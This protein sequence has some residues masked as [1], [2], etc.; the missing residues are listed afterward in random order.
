MY[1]NL[2]YI[3]TVFN[4]DYVPKN[5]S[6]ELTNLG[7]EVESFDRKAN[8]LDIAITPN[9]GD[10]FS[11]LGIARELSLSTKKSENLLKNII[12]S[13][14]VKFKQSEKKHLGANSFFS[15]EI[16]LR[17][18]NETKITN[19]SYSWRSPK[20]YEIRASVDGDRKTFGIF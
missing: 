3:K 20:F 15:A 19:A 6:D 16:K 14:K 12:L 11:H 17:Y 1:I 9:R 5:V 13:K 2:N 8:I 10:C 4:I 7:L 18:K